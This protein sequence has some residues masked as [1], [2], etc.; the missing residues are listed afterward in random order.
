MGAGKRVIPI[1][2]DIDF[3]F[4]KRNFYPEAGDKSIWF[5]RRTVVDRRA[6][7]VYHIKGGRE[8]WGKNFT[9]VALTGN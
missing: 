3:I 4:V 8:G 6:G 9:P 7:T 1:F 2:V 5:S